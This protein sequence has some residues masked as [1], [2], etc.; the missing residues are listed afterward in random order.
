MW[1]WNLYILLKRNESWEIVEKN[2]GIVSGIAS[3]SL[4][5]ILGF[6]LA[7]LVGYYL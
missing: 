3:L 7:C 2:S 4:G 6:L 1:E 5:A